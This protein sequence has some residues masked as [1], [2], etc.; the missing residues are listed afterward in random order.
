MFRVDKESPGP[1]STL[2]DADDKPLPPF[3]V[4]NQRELVDLLCRLIESGWLCEMGEA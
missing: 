1:N 4:E 3:P 2:T